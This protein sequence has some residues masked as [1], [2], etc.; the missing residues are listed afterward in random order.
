NNRQNVILNSC[1]L[2]LVMF[3]NFCV[4]HPY[5]ISKYRYAMHVRVAITR[6]VYSKAL[7]VTNPAIQRITV[8]KIV[9]LISND[10]SRFDAAYFYVDFLYL[11]PLETAVGIFLLYQYIGRSCFGALA[12]V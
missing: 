5:F 2:G 3:A 9:N 4:S 12:I 11:A 8:G 6:L 7:K 10:A 1:L